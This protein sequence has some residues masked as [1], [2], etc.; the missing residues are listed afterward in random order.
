MEE[1]NAIRRASTTPA[2]RLKSK[3]CFLAMPLQGHQGGITLHFHA[4]LAVGKRSNDEVEQGTRPFGRFYQN[5]LAESIIQ[6][7]NVVHFR[8]HA[9]C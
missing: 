4:E 8:Q 2:W 6:Q 1:Y 7:C 5:V 9:H 3:N